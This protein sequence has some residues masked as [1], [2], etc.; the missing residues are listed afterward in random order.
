MGNLF[1]I[2]LA[3]LGYGLGAV[4]YK[5]A[6]DSAHPIITCAI[7][8][9]LNI[10]LLPLGFI[11]FRVAPSVN[12]TGFWFSLLGAA[13]TCIGTLCYFFAQKNLG[14]GQIA[15]VVGVYPIVTIIISALFL[16]ETFSIKKIIGCAFAII[17]VVMLTS[18]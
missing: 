9:G 11:Y 6:S 15:A 12:A 3:I 7:M 1:I 14:A 17:A 8:A 16:G 18:K 10:T 13:C 2:I 4:F 5:I